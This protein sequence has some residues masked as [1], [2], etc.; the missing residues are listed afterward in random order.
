MKGNNFSYSY[1]GNGV[2]Y[3]KIVNGLTT[4]YYYNGTQLLMENRNGGRIYYLYGAS[5]I[6][7]FI[8]ERTIGTYYYYDKNTLGD[9][10]AI[11]N[12]DGDIVAKYEYNAWGKVTVK[13]ENGS[14]NKSP[15][16]IGNVN[17]FR[18]R[19]YY[20]DAETGFYYLQTRYY[21]P[22]ICRFI[23]ADD[24]ELTA[25]LSEIPGQLNLYAYCNNNPIMFTDES[26][27][28]LL[29]VLI[30]ALIGAG[31]SA[32]SSAITQKLTTGEVDWGQVGIS[33]VFGAVGGALGVTGI[34]GV[35]GQF[36]IQGILGVGETYSLAALGG[37]AGSI[38]IGEILGTFVLSGTLGTY[39]A[40]GAA[41]GFKRI[42]QI[43]KSF[44]KY[45][46]RDISRYGK[47]IIK[48]ISK[49]GAKYINQFILPTFK[50]SLIT[51]GISA[52]ISCFW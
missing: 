51:G 22:E 20:Y 30:G 36:A 27:T 47:S 46:K 23:N 5:G 21:D 38:G 29:T 41:K 52:G 4:D 32:V 44:V 48:T 19:G 26:G 42:G 40:K 7:G 31:I 43:E 25:T 16:F 15:S 37:T 6:E 49:R 17:P 34:G 39:G 10:V 2:R 1:D 24:Y 12:K 8:D 33:A 35:A 45:A 13:D 3:E 50:N 11:R 9:I 18:Y 14:I 28:I